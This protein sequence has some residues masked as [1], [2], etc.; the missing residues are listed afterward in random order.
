MEQPAMNHTLLSKLGDYYLIPHELLHVLAYRL[1]NQPCHYEWGDR[2]VQSTAKLT[3]RQDLFVLLLPFAVFFGLGLLTHVVGLAV[4]V[5]I[6]FTTPVP[7]TSPQ[8]FLTAMPKLPF[9]LQLVA[10]LLI[11]YSG[12]GYNDIR[13][14]LRILQ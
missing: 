3:R 14:A 11:I 12:T 7:T 1:L 4:W 6:L 2:Q 9:I 8:A 13:V 10:T 5:V